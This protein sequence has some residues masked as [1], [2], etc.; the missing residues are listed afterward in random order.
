MYPERYI[1]GMRYKL[2]STKQFD[3]WM[4]GLKDFSVKTKILARLARIENGNF[5][6]FKQIDSSL[7]ELRFFFGSG[8]RI[9]Y[10]IRN[11]QVV[12]LLAGGNKSSQKR[13]IEKAAGL[14]GELED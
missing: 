7:F 4:A 9:Y 1:K 6:D 2:Q 5:G 12:F 11:G 13:D 3:R 14:L 8:L 10:T